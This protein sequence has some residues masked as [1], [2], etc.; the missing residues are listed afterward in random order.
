MKVFIFIS[1]LFLVFAFVPGSQAE[2]YQYKDKNGVVVITDKK[3]NSA[4]KVTTFKTPETAA[5][6]TGEQDSQKENTSKKSEAVPPQSIDSEEKKAAA[7]A[8]KKRNE[9]ADRLEAEARM[10]EQFSKE[11]QIEQREKLERA[12]NLRKGVDQ[13]S[14]S[15][16]R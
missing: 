3:P 9:E 1:V 12:R 11:K 8:Q 5:D 14:D 7:E 4:K 16:G 13:P 10:T 15:A 2:I 6:K